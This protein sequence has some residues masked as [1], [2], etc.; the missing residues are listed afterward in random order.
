MISTICAPTRR[1]SKIA[2]VAS[3]ALADGLRKDGWDADD[4]CAKNLRLTWRRA[5]GARS[6]GRLSLVRYH[7]SEVDRMGIC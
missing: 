5:C 2:R 3:L 7:C 4:N 6:Y 1:I